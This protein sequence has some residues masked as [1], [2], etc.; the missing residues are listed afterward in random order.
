MSA[1]PPYAKRARVVSDCL[2]IRCGARGWAHM[3][4][5][6]DCGEIVWPAAE[7]P[8]AHNWSFARGYHCYVVAGD[9]PS[10]SVLMLVREL[11][12]QGAPSVDVI[13]WNLM[14]SGTRGLVG[15][16]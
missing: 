7:P 15:F 10:A 16:G 12:T 5:N 13:D 1:Y 3:K 8:D 6:P 9:V 4:A 14:G 11:L 2:W